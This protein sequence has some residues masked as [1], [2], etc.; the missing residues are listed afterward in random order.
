[1]SG[2]KSWLLIG[3]WTVPGDVC[4]GLWVDL[5]MVDAQGQLDPTLV[6]EGHRISLLQS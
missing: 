1:M 4:S 3:K 5:W 2:R 6:P